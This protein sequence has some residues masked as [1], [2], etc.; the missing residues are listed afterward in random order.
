LQGKSQLAA[1]QGGNEAERRG[2][3]GR[4]VC[5]RDGDDAAEVS[6]NAEYAS[7]THLDIVRRKIRIEVVR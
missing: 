3:A 7:E 6:K 1:K 2:V 5:T 4:G